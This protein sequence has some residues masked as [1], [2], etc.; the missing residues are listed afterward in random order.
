MIEGISTRQADL[1]S[2]AAATR[3][4]TLDLDEALANARHAQAATTLSAVRDSND[5]G[6]SR[7]MKAHL[8]AFPGGPEIYALCPGCKVH[9]DGGIYP[10]AEL[11]RAEGCPTGAR[12]PVEASD[13]DEGE[14][15]RR[16]EREGSA[17]TGPEGRNS[18]S[19]FSS[20]DFFLLT[21]LKGLCSGLLG[22]MTH[23]AP[24]RLLAES[25]RRL[26]R[27]WY[28]HRRRAICRQRLSRIVSGP[29]S[30]F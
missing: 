13:L 14:K 5:I 4:A 10:A 18:L 24:Q 7:D 27:Y 26:R 12:V 9:P 30:T 23:L 20:S 25:G 21:E 8:P 2:S 29:S 15:C 17:H 16:A 11:A 22:S 3:A 1:F 19:H 28:F 6:D